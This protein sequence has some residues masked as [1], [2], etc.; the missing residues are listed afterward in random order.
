M[1]PASVCGDVAGEVV[2]HVGGPGFDFC[3]AHSGLHGGVFEPLHGHGYTVRV[4]VRGRPAPAGMLA[5]FRRV[6]AVLRAHISQ[7]NNRTLI[8]T[9][10]PGV[11]VNVGD[12]AVHVRG[13]GAR[14]SLP[15]AWVVLMPTPDTSTE[16]IAAYLL[17]RL[18][19]DI[20]DA[21]PQADALR[22]TVEESGTCGAT[23]E[24]LWS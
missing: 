17:D 2:L 7:L 8:A 11:A 4:S 9:A 3:A 6:K 20:R 15:R 21:A 12:D 1:M 22:V 18:A 13:G 24:L 16:G 14:F 23:V 5:D 10:A 19:P